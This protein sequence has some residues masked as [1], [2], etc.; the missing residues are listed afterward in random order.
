[1]PFVDL[2]PANKSTSVFDLDKVTLKKDEKARLVV[3]DERPDGEIVHYVTTGTGENER[4]RYY[5]CLGD[6]DIVKKQGNDPE[7]CPACKAAESGFDAVRSAQ[8]RFAFNVARYRTNAKGEPTTP[9]SLA[10]QIWVISNDKYNQIVD[11]KKE[12][13]DAPCAQ[14]KGDPRK[15]D[16]VVTCTAQQYQNMKIDFSPAMLLAKDPSAIAQYKDLQG[17][18]AT[19]AELD[20]LLGERISF[21]AMERIINGATPSIGE[22]E[23]DAAV[24]GAIDDIMKDMGKEAGPA[25]ALD[26]E[27]PSFDPTA[28]DTSGEAPATE[29]IDLAAL[30][31]IDS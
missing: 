3:L 16:M 25:A 20:R 13:E 15:H 31:N 1:M 18:K 27:E 26:S 9:L 29:E 10:H 30:L 22:D 2:D 8:R 6:R 24:G 14:C 17:S 28:D 4:F 23:V 11:T 12:H 21:E 19:E 5:V 7:R